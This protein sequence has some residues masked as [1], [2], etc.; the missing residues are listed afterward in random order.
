MTQ[1]LLNTTEPRN[2]L[3]IKPNPYR[4]LCIFIFYFNHLFHS[5]LYFLMQSYNLG[6]R[7]HSCGDRDLARAHSCEANNLYPSSS[8]YFLLFYSKIDMGFNQP[9]QPLSVT[10]FD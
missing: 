1:S 9:D 7:A 5:T 4:T 10:P 2:E 8:S 3:G 6:F